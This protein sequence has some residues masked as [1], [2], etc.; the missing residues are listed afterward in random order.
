MDLRT[1]TILLSLCEILLA[2]P[3][4]GSQKD[5]RQGF[6]DAFD[7]GDLANTGAFSSSTNPFGSISSGATTGSNNA[8]V[9]N[10]LQGLISP[11]GNP[12]STQNASPSGANP[13]GALFS[14]IIPS[15]SGSG[16]PTGT[17][18]MILPTGTFSSGSQT[19]DDETNQG[20]SGFGDLSLGGEGG[21]DADEGN[22][23]EGESDA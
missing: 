20:L 23:P 11:T 13:F 14:G 5:K 6:E 21:Q 17:G 15:T 16:S 10:G 8:G 4:Q 12:S 19:G 1:V 7:F 18:N 9:L 3:I 22:S 2:V